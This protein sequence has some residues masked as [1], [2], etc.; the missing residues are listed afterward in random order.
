MYYIVIAYSPVKPGEYLYFSGWNGTKDIYTDP[1]KIAA[2]KYS[3][4]RE[5]Q[6]ERRRIIKLEKYI[7]TVMK[8]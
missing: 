1:V 7:A 4:E 6:L 2:I 5:A 3:T 8:G